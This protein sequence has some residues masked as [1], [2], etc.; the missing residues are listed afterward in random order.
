MCT[1]I[2]SKL[3][4]KDYV[5]IPLIWLATNRTGELQ[6]PLY[7][8]E[9]EPKLGSW[10]LKIRFKFEVTTLDFHALLENS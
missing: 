9:N 10:K 5:E 1:E 7:K 4:R 8:A 2:D 6:I 3:E